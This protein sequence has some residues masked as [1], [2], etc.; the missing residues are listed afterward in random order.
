MSRYRSRLKRRRVRSGRGA[1]NRPD[2]C[3]RRCMVL[4]R[5]L[6]MVPAVNGVLLQLSRATRRSGRKCLVERVINVRSG[7]IELPDFQRYLSPRKESADD[8]FD[9]HGWGARRSADAGAG[10]GRQRLRSGQRGLPA[11]P[12]AVRERLARSPHM[13]RLRPADA[14]CAVLTASAGRPAERPLEPR[15]PATKHRIGPSAFPRHFGDS[16]QGRVR[17]AASGVLVAPQTR[18]VPSREPATPALRTLGMAVAAAVQAQRAGYSAA[19]FPAE[20]GAVSARF[21]ASM[22]R[23][24]RRATGAERETKLVALAFPL[25]PF[26]IPL[27]NS[28][29]GYFGEGFGIV[30]Y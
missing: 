22:R 28:C 27:R 30:R 2:I 23:N 20:L 1:R 10:A 7:T 5:K 6:S 13:Q 25:R 3:A 11:L 15:Q 9:Q 8:T 29:V 24:F 19:D 26:K 12:A 4:V 21:S 14:G 18:C 17:T 16:S